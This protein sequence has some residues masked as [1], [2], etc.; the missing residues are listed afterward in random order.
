MLLIWKWFCSWKL[1]QLRMERKNKRMLCVRAPF[2]LVFTPVDSVLSTFDISVLTLYSMQRNK[3]SSLRHCNQPTLT[4]LFKKSQFV[5]SVLSFKQFPRTHMKIDISNNYYAATDWNN[6][7]IMMRLYQ[8]IMRIKIRRLAW[9]GAMWN[10]Y[11]L[12]HEMLSMCCSLFYL[13]QQI[14]IAHLICILWCF[15]LL[16]LL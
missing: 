8:H 6:V 14:S 13:S 5:F 2:N 3:N 10:I 7:V 12:C 1:F 9:S 11:C 16:P 4:R 15:F